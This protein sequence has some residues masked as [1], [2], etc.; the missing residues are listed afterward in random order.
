MTGTK[1]KDSNST[2]FNYWNAAGTKYT[3]IASNKAVSM[4]QPFE[5]DE[6]AGKVSSD[7]WNRTCTVGI[8]AQE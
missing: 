3:S 2:H 6:P 1:P 4:H 5:R 7:S 8:L